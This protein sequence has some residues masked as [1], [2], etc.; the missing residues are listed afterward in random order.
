[1]E[2]TLS[3]IPGLSI[4]TDY[5]STAQESELTRQIDTNPW[6]TSMKRR[7]QHYGYI[8]DYR[9]RTVDPSM[10]LGHLP[11]WLMPLAAQ[12]H[13]EGYFPAMPDQCIVN[14]YEPGQGISPHVDCEPCFGDVIAS[15]SLLSGCMMHFDHMRESRRVSVYLTP[16][17][18]VVMT[19]E[20]RYGWKHSIPG[21]LTDKLEGGSVKRT[22]R[23]AGTCRTVVV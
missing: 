6:I 22:R 14:E 23:L 19:G 4:I 3:T 20:A 11:Q 9:R 16:R 10:Y 1:M 5:I 18:L 13:T 2:R 8:Y 17:S 12:M 15:L 21:R 7:L